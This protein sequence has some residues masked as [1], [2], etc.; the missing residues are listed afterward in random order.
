MACVSVAEVLDDNT[1]VL[2]DIVCEWDCFGQRL[3]SNRRLDLHGLRSAGVLTLMQLDIPKMSGNINGASPEGPAAGCLN[4]SR[5][6][7]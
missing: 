5:S 1:C 3:N 2:L 6:S 4:K 7:R